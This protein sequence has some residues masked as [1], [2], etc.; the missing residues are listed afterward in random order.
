MQVFF[1]LCNSIQKSLIPFIE[2]NLSPLTKKEKEFVLVA[3]LA[4]IDIAIFAFIACLRRAK[5]AYKQ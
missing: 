3:E 4:A 1:S 5:P 2:D